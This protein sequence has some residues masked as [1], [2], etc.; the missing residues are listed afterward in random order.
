[1]ENID[2]LFTTRG[3]AE[4]LLVKPET[5]HTWVH[6]GV[7]NPLKLRG[8]SLRFKRFKTLLCSGAGLRVPTIHPELE[9]SFQFALR[10]GAYRQCPRLC[11]IRPRRDRNTRL[12]HSDKTRTGFKKTRLVGGFW[13]CT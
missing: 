12:K 8:W 11:P 9:A 2:E 5:V 7:L 6:R 10:Q 1:M 3:A 4:Y 13:G